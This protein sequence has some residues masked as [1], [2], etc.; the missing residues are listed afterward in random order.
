MQDSTTCFRCLTT[1]AIQTTAY[2]VRCWSC[3]A[4][5][6]RNG[7]PIP[8]DNRKYRYESQIENAEKRI[9]DANPYKE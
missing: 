7:R 1:L 3:D 4:M 8:D 6:S 9:S 2:M 5:V